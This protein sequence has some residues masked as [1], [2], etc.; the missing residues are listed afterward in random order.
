MTDGD[1]YGKLELLHTEDETLG[2]YVEGHHDMEQFKRVAI[3]F[4]QVECDM[5]VSEKYRKARLGYHKVV[6]R[7]HKLPMLYFSVQKMRGSKPV[8]EMRYR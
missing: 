1:I 2:C 3:D 7:L 6:P 8:M 4:L 5:I